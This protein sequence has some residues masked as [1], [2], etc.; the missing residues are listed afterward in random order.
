[1]SRETG[2]RSIAPAT[3]L[4]PQASPPLQSSGRR[5]AK[6]TPSGCAERVNNVQGPLNVP[7]RLPRGSTHTLASALQK[8]LLTIETGRADMLRNDT[9]ALVGSTSRAFHV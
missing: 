9:A 5:I 3:H 6:A 7:T 8:R 2:S 1:T 4:P